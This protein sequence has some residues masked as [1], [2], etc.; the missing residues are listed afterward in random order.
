MGLFLIQYSGWYFERYS[1][2]RPVE[3]Y[4]TATPGCSLNNFVYFV[5]MFCRYIVIHSNVKPVTHVTNNLNS[6]D[7]SNRLL[8]LMKLDDVSAAIQHRRYFK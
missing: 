4:L 3:T 8:R 2:T 6:E 7:V 5:V 1:N